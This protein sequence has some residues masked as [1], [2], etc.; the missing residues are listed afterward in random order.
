MR[1]ALGTRSAFATVVV[2]LGAVVSF[3][4]PG[5]AVPGDPA[6]DAVNTFEPLEPMDVP[7]RLVE[8]EATNPTR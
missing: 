6:M 8:P 4:I 7:R 2:A 1:R 3:L 5:V